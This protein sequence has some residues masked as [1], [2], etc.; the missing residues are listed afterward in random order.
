MF[1]PEL[2]AG[3][4]AQHVLSICC[5]P[6]MVFGQW[7]PCSLLLGACL[8]LCC[9]L[10]TNSPVKETP[11]RSQFTDFLKTGIQAHQMCPIPGCLGQNSRNLNHGAPMFPCSPTA[12]Q[13]CCSKQSQG[14]QRVLEVGNKAPWL[15]EGRK[16]SCLVAWRP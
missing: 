10:G 12:C 6:A 7:F 4:M 1:G 9:L 5:V 2:P 13:R 15:R 11:S 8:S 14:L 16:A 3:P